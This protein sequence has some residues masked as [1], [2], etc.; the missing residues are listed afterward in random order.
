[1]PWHGGLMSEM[2]GIADRLGLSKSLQEVM[3]M[4]DGGRMRTDD[5][6]KA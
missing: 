1:M 2:H 5:G 3:K 4:V 6:M